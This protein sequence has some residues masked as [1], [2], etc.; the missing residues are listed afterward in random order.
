MVAGLDTLRTEL[1]SMKQLFALTCAF[2]FVTGC[3]RN[4]A[5]P[6]TRADTDTIRTIVDSILPVA[7]EIRRF[8]LNRDGIT[9]TELSSAA[10]SRDAL[11]QMFI[12]AVEKR[13]S[14]TLAAIAMNAAEFIDLYYPT[15]QFG[16]PPYK[17]SPEL[18]WFL[19]TENSDKGVNRLLQRFSGRTTGFR[20]YSCNPQPVIEGENRIWDRC[21]VTWSH[22]P[23][24]IRLFSSIIE[25]N[26]R[27]KI[28]SYANGL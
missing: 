18:R 25:R 8:K 5:A 21:T 22:E 3:G 13:D 9:A 6:A 12:T 26:G 14:V 11:V 10:T 19:L 7:E 17:Q 24:T 1:A 15:S 27:F 20:S 28:M 23:R 16:R 4:E 2:A